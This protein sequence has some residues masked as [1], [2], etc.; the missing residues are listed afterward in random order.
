VVKDL[1]AIIPFGFQ[2]YRSP[3]PQSTEWEQDLQQMA[4]LGFN[5]VKY[6]V[7]WRA[8]HPEPNRYVF[9]D[10]Q[11]LMDLA[12]ENGLKVVL[13]IIFDVAPAWFYKQYPESLM[14]TASGEILHPTAISSRQIGGAPGPC[15]HHEEAAR[16]KD[17]FL[18]ETVR[19]F[20]HHPALLIW[21]LWNEPELTLGIKRELTFDN[22]VCYCDKSITQFQTWLQLKYKNID[23]FNEKWQ[24]TYLTWSEIEAPRRQAVFNDMVDWRLFFVDTITNEMKRRAEVV[25]SLDSLNPVMCHTVPSPIFN[26]ITAGSDDFELAKPCDLFGNSLG[27]SAWSADLLKSAAQGK[28]LIN[29][30]IHALPGH[31]ALKPNKL[32]WKVLKKHILIPLSRGITGFIFWQYR[33]E[34]LGHESP[35]WG[36][37][38]MD[39]RVT[40]WLKQTAELNRIIQEN[41][42]QL[43]QGRRMSDGMA[44]L[45]SA[46]GQIANFA[47]FGHLHSYEQAM[48]G[49]HRLLHDLNYKIE[50]IHEKDVNADNLSTYRCLWMPFPIYLNALLCESIRK[51]VENGGILISE[52][53]FGALQAENGMHSYTVPG[54]GFD[55][56]FGVKEQWIHSVEHLDHS[57]HMVTTENKASVIPLFYEDEDSGQTSALFGSTYQTEIQYDSNVEVLAWYSNDQSA[58]ITS[59]SY[60]AGKAVWIGT[61]LGAAYY[62]QPD[63]NT[64]HF[65]RELLHSMQIDP[66]IQVSEDG[67]RVDIL[68]SLGQDNAAEALLFIENVLGEDVEVEIKIQGKQPVTSESWFEDG[69]FA[70][71][72]SKIYVISKA[73]DI[74][75]MRCLLEMDDR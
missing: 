45:F 25:R 16:W 74:Q 72:E 30:E 41:R 55:D 64:R 21:D 63:R 1:Q 60:G 35:A 57:Y 54:Y 31:M 39:G 53:S 32:E 56:V 27:S 8:S 49:V 70:I 10:I 14:V 7:Q 37:S 5:T 71:K 62:Q 47:T 34:T 2:Y 51:W 58:A 68:E 4:G 18:L 59:H 24:R 52:C 22:Q 67:V 69:A 15:F 65:F 42:Q 26:L 17:Q 9:D 75:V 29:S 11:R 48:Q 44:I 73:N 23:N 38:Y 46:E 40:P 19:R 20:Q 12:E 6:W 50:F 43:V 61:L 33:P 3:T 66:Y 36:S 28:K 13:N